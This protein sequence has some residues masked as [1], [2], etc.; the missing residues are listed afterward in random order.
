MQ[1][2]TRRLF[3]YSAVAG[4]A[5]VMTHVL[6]GQATP[7]WVER[8]RH[9]GYGTCGRCKRPW[10]VV[11]SH[12]TTY[13]TAPDGMTSSGIFALCKHCWQELATPSER[14]PYYQHVVD[15]WEAGS[16]ADKHHGLLWA[17]VRMLVHAAVMRG[18]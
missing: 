11:A 15:Q 13:Y 14:L 5:P 6:L 2:I 10:A 1:A 9:P 18:E 16:R 3:L 17:E 7:A 4:A 12:D 8:L